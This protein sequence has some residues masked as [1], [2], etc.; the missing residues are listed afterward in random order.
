[1]EH[2]VLPSRHND[3]RLWEMAAGGVHVRK[4]PV[5]VVGIDELGR[6]ERM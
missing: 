2:L 3:V 1:M 4:K 6:P 5:A